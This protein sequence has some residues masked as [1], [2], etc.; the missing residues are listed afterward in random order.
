MTQQQGYDCGA[1]QDYTTQTQITDVRSREI[2]WQ[3][4]IL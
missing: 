1:K 3:V 4:N 2:M